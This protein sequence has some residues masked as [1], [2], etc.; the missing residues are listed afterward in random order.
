[1]R[2]TYRCSNIK[3]CM[4]DENQRRTW[5]YL[6]RITRKDGSYGKILSDAF[7]AVLNVQIQAGTDKAMSDPAVSLEKDAD[8]LEKMLDRA[9]EQKF[10]EI[11]QEL[12]R[13]L[14][15]QISNSFS[16]YVS[17]VHSEA[18]KLMEKTDADGMVQMQEAELSEDMMAFAFAMGE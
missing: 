18:E 4:E 5:E 17:A 16:E 6:Q 3:F 8:I 7:V 15:E 2:K 12:Q 13:V 14:T 10:H 9:L 1:M 11:L